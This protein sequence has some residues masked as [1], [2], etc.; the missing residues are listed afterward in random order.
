MFI[1]DET[2]ILFLLFDEISTSSFQISKENK[3]IYHMM[4]NKV[5]LKPKKRNLWNKK[6]KLNF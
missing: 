1:E 4:I 3:Q 6:Q 5:N 2:K